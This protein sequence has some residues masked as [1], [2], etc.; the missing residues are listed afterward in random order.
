MG[1]AATS[2]TGTGFGSGS[3]EGTGRSEAAALQAHKPSSCWKEGLFERPLLMPV[4]DRCPKHAEDACV[5]QTCTRLKEG[6]HEWVSAPGTKECLTQAVL[7][8]P[9]LS[10][11]E[12][13]CT[14]SS[15]DVDIS[16]LTA[17]TSKRNALCRCTD[18]LWQA[19]VLDHQTRNPD[20]V[21]IDHVSTHG[22]HA[23]DCGSKL[24]CANWTQVVTDKS[25]HSRFSLNLQACASVI[26]DLRCPLIP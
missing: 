12:Y 21:L 25:K 13:D 14:R 4:N 23:G 18:L 1:S 24:C 6:L 10:K 26:S 22:S 2:G 15:A 8:K 5:H 19:D 16:I 17:V 9:Q 20:M 3:S 7:G 11:I